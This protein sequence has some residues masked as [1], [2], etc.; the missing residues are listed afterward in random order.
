MRL[1]RKVPGPD[2]FRGRVALVTGAAG[3]LGAPIAEALAARGARVVLSGRNE[4]A[5]EEVRRD[6]DVK[7]ADVAVVA[8]DLADRDQLL[9]LASRAEQPFGPLDLLVN[10]AGQELVSAFAAMSPDEIEN[11]LMVN[12]R[13]PLLLTR[14][15]LP[16][17]HARGSGHIVCVGSLGGFMGSAYMVPYC[18]TKGGMLRMVQ[19]LR[20]EYAG[21]GVGL[22]YVAPGFVDGG[23]YQPF[24]DAGLKASIAMGLST[25]AAVADAV[26]DAVV[27]DRPEVLVN[28]TPTRPIFT[29]GSAAPRFAELVSKTLGAD[30]VLRK[31][32]AARGRSLESSLD[33]R[34]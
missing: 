33:Q 8:A 6:L 31:L 34:S 32:A 23:M 4:E 1:G 22:S 18:T 27:G 26:I 11:I 9:A 17:M 3:G 29:L 28:P 10:N 5:L 19:A 7:G 24:K 14:Q 15:V 25:T 16:G 13:A 12:L 30:D 20:A 21:T 2:R